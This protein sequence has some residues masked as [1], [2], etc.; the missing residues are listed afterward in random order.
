MFYF[1]TK[2]SHCMRNVEITTVCVGEVGM[3]A[4]ENCFVLGNLKTKQETY[5]I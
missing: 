1:N 2:K 4:V 5:G 3:N